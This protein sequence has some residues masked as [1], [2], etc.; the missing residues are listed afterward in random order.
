MTEKELQDIDKKLKDISYDKLIPQILEELAKISVKELTIS[1]FEN[2]LCTCYHLR[3]DDNTCNIICEFDPTNTVFTRIL[4]E[5]KAFKT[6]DRETISGLLIYDV[7]LKRVYTAWGL[8][9][10][11]SDLDFSWQQISN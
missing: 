6:K 9:R 1:F 10:I 5:E 7:P 8:K 2:G 11:T 4:K 3:Y